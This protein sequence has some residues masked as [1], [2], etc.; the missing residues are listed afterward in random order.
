MHPLLIT[1]VLIVA[2]STISPRSF[3]SQSPTTDSESP[4]N[5]TQP[6]GSLPPR[7]APNEGWHGN[8]QLWASLPVNGIFE[9]TEEN[10]GAD[11]SLGGKIP[12]YRAAPGGH[13]SIKGHLLNDPSVQLTA[14]LP[15]GYG[16]VGI[17]ASG[18]SF[19][20]PGCWIIEGSVPQATLTFTLLVKRVE[21]ESSTPN[22]T[23]T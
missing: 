18:L 9:V 19:P 17:Q 16:K 12:W 1:L 13:L 21:V 15:P 7:Q 20:V 22:A 23:P 11:G 14:G 5:V 8:G 3:A 2:S 4:C 6:N 10:I